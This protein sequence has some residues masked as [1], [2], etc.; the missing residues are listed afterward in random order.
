AVGE[1]VHVEALVAQRA[2]EAFDV[3]ILPRT[4]RRDVER[5]RAARFEPALQGLRDE[6]RTIVAAQVLRRAVQHEQPFKDVDDALRSDAGLDADRQA[7]ASE[8]VEHRQDAQLP[9]AFGAVLKKIIGPY[10]L[11]SF[12]FLYDLAWRPVMA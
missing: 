7:L 2:V 3:G 10:V 8:L 9:A 6:L 11:W 4:A 1:E 12:R 5:L